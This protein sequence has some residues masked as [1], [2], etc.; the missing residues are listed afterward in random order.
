MRK[1]TCAL[2]LLVGCTHPVASALRS[3]HETVEL[4]YEERGELLGA[5]QIRVAPDGRIERRRWRPDF[6]TARDHPE[7]YLRADEP[8]PAD[9]AGADVVE[10]GSI[11]AS[12]RASLDAL[13]LDLE[14]WEQRVDEGVVPVDASRAVL[15]LRAPDGHSEVWEWVNDLQARERLVRVKTRLQELADAHAR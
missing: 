9:G 11:T 1:S 6:A 4:V 5:E 3:P 7:A 15:T 2:L 13:L 8:L 14:A 10:V 12:E